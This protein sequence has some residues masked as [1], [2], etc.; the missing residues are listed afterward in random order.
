MTQTYLFQSQI[1]S[2]LV[3]LRAAFTVDCLCVCMCVCVRARVCARECMHACVSYVHG[4]RLVF[5]GKTLKG[6]ELGFD[7]G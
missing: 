6:L 5:C 2:L 4:A 7:V 1:H 3:S